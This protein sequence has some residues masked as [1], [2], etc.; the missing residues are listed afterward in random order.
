MEKYK[1][2]YIIWANY[3][4]EEKNITTSS[5]YLS[6][7]MME[8]VGIKMPSYNQFLLDISKDIPILTTNGYWGANGT[9][10]AISD[11]DSPYYDL[12]EK[13]NIM[14]YNN[15]FDKN[16]RIEDFFYIQ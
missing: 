8:N 13:Y 6:S 16:N 3:D 9:Y 2:P 7:I 11:T 15:M 5:N 14:Q 10:Y 1:V 12:V 4:I